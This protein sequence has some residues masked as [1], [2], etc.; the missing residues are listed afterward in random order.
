MNTQSIK[1]PD[2]RHAIALAIDRQSIQSIYGGDI[3]GTVA[4]SV[5]PPDIPGYVAPNLG[6]T[7]TGNPDEAK[8]LLEGKSVPPLHMAVS[9]SA[10]GADEQEVRPRSRPTSRRRAS[11]WSST[12]TPTRSFPPSSR[13]SRVGT[14]TQS[15]GWCFDWPTAAAVVLPLMGPNE[16]GTSWGSNNPGKYFDPEVLRSTA[17]TEVL[18]RGLGGDRQ[19]VRRHRQRDPDDCA[20]RSCPHCMKTTPR[21]SAQT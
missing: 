4:D 9:D 20:G 2:V 11:R 14:S 21:W 12:H 10:S 1:D 18:D 6:L 19:E 15:G 7:P 5:I 13:E 16:D 8:K 3:Y 17:G